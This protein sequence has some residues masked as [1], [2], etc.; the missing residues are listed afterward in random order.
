MSKPQIEKFT[1]GISKLDN[2]LDGGIP[3]KHQVLITGTAGTMKSSL[4]FQIAYANVI[5]DKK[6]VYVT[7]EQNADSIITQMM[8][9]NFD[10]SKIRVSSNNPQVNSML[11]ASKSK[12]GMLTLLDIGYI[13]AKQGINQKFSWLKEIKKE[14]TKYSKS[15]MADILVLD[16]LTALTNME[17]F[18]DTRGQLF[19][20]FEYL[21]SLKTTSL[22]INEMPSGDEGYSRHGIESYLVD[23]VI[24]LSSKERKLNMN[25][26]INIVKMRYAD[27]AT[28]VFTLT[29]KNGIFIISP[30]QML[31][32]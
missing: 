7:L 18:K 8:L 21:K 1:T 31:E 12:K 3:R 29:F 10:F 14:L 26:E 22:I 6:V 15:G 32:E 16:S 4:A 24:L 27:H 9:M 11:P 30:K 25:R 13:R 28:N 19:H 5:K 17:N 23:G 20:V 2:Y